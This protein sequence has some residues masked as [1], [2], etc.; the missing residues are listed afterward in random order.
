MNAYLLDILRLLPVAQSRNCTAIES[1]VEAL[2]K[3]FN[4]HGLSTYASCQGHWYMPTGAYVAFMAQ[5]TAQGIDQVC[6]LAQH[7]DQAQRDSTVAMHWT[8]RIEP[9]FRHVQE[10]WQWTP[11]DGYAGCNTDPIKFV[12]AFCLRPSPTGSRWNRL[13]CNLIPRGRLDRDFSQLERL[14]N[15][16]F[17]EQLS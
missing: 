4:R 12:V 2:V 7:L 10:E 8:W 16:H 11:T 17:N 15:E 5:P 1:H 14:L 9:S 13:I 3:A 6:R